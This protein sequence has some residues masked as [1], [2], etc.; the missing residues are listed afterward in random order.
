[1]D[2]DDFR[3]IEYGEFHTLII[4]RHT[5]NEFDNKGR[6]DELL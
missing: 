2:G 6:Y 5:E 1:M 3:G 4:M